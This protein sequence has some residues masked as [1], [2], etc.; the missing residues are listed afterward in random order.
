M[1]SIATLLYSPDY[2]PGALVLGHIL[3]KFSLPDTRLVILIDS[4][5]FDSAQLLALSEVW[6]V[7]ED[8]QI[9]DSH[10]TSKLTADLKRPELASTFTKIQLWKLPY[11]TVLYLD[12]DTLP[13]VGPLN[14]T[15]LLKLQ[16]PTHKI[17]ASPDSGFPDV[18]NSGVFMLHPN[19]TDF[20]N[21][22]QLVQ[23][24]GPDISFDGADQGLLNQYFNADP[25]WV[26]RHLSS[27]NAPLTTSD[28]CDSNWIRVPF[29]YNT[30]PNAHYEYYPASNH[31]GASLQI[32]S[33]NDKTNGR[34]VGSGHA[35]IEK[36]T[37]PHYNAASP[38]GDVSFKHFAGASQSQIKLLHYIGPVKPWKALCS[39][40]FEPWWKEWFDY[41]GGKSIDE[42]I[43]TF[44]PT[45]SP[46]DL[47]ESVDIPPPKPS[48]AGEILPSELCNP[49]NYQQFASNY[50]SFANT[51]DATKEPPPLEAPK[52]D[53]LDDEVKASRSSWSVQRPDAP[54]PA[55]SGSQE[56]IKLSSVSTVVE[57]NHEDQ[58]A[59]RVFDDAYDYVPEHLLLRKTTEAEAEAEAAIEYEDI[60][61]EESLD[62]EEENV[63]EAIE[64]SSEATENADNGSTPYSR[65]FPWEFREN[66][67]P[68]RS[69]D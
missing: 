13:L 19:D 14:V 10:L 51:W 40:I 32:P 61:E 52:V 43:R 28:T 33:A 5:R 16:F 8:T 60:L 31:F 63:L 3:R 12:A 62:E 57:G 59:E 41:S 20:Q 64:Q 44:N 6:H 67:A 11:E 25:D 37:S 24:K 58:I 35:A 9:L 17:V 39:G 49:E 18:F 47:S 26:V 50:V 38:Y 7:L 4:A 23:S 53:A 46:P 36:V 21:L 34:G 27:G 22:V 29:L 65:I 42:L 56:T 68:T 15:D 54:A 55:K 69:W 1:K 2:L 45:L 66:I 30:T 48:L